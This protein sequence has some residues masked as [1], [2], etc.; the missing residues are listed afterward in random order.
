MQSL[1]AEKYLF[2][3]KGYFLEEKTLFKFPKDTA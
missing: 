2:L 1:V 3:N